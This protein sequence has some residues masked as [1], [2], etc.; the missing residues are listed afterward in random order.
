MSIA[1]PG[2]VSRWIVAVKD[3]NPGAAHSLWKRYHRLLVGVAR[4]ML[5]TANRAAL[6]EEDVVQNVFHSFFQAV[7]RGR[8]PQLDDRHG[9][10]RLLVVITVNKTLRQLHY[11]RRQKRCAATATHP[12]LATR[13]NPEE[14]ESALLQVAAPEPSPDFAAQLQEQC[15]RLLSLLGDVTLRS[16]A[17][18]KMEGYG[19]DEIAQMLGCSRRTVARKLDSIREL[20]RHCSAY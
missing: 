18:W 20:W 12:T 10:W 5:R 14:D 19:N 4:K 9:L 6:D 11:E 13:R 15:S 8:F 2:S 7:Q 17:I 16:V 3:G 1:S